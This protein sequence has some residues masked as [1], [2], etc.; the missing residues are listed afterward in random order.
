MTELRNTEGGSR[1]ET[2]RATTAEHDASG[3]LV[4]DQ[5]AAFIARYIAF[6]SE[7]ALTAVTLWAAHTHAANL[8]Y[9]TP[10]LVL[11]SAEPGS[12]KTRVLELLNLLV[13]LPEMT[14]SVST[15]ALFRLISMQ[16]YTIL[17]DEV[18]AIF[19]PKTGGNYEDLRALLNSGYKKGATVA[20][21]VGDA[22]S[23]NV[24]RFPVFAP[25]ALAGIAGGMPATILTRAVVIHMRRRARS[26]H[27]EPFYEEDAAGEAAPIRE[28]LADWVAERAEALAAARPRMPDGIVDRPAEVWKAL[29]AVADE[30]GAGWPDAGRAAARYFVLDTATTPTFGTRLLADLRVLFAGRDRMP[31]ADILD[32]LVNADEGPWGDL[33]GKPLDARRLS[34]EL[35]RYG[36]APIGFKYRLPDGT[37]KGAKGYTTYANEDTAGLADA[38]ERYLLPAGSG[39]PGNSGNRAGQTGYRSEKPSVTIG[40]PQP[41]VTDPSVTAPASVTALSREV[42]E[43]TAVTATARPTGAPGIGNRRPPTRDRR[44]PHS[45]FKG[46]AA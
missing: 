14:I 37:V 12:G 11:D 21:C 2:S 19:N 33:G 9:V 30:A 23:M 6:P 4:L 15:A 31:T 1:D 44:D 18:D 43:V 24:R 40:N 13:R 3:A 36:V 38:W 25:V 17:F 45:P 26:E 16:P 27:V 46:A 5:V 42:T 22:K 7:H 34:K 10:R 20:R 8:F 39:N 35:G 29:L 28:A 32:A 41:A